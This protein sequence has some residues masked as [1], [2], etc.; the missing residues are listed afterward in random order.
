ME[1]GSWLDPV[2][3]AVEVGREAQVSHMELCL[4][5]HTPLSPPDCGVSSLSLSLSLTFIFE[6][7]LMSRGGAERRGDRGS[8]AGSALSAQIP[9]RGSSPRTVR[10]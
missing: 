2:G 6:R 5:S 1:V 4:S 8:E 9:M 7:E 3:L 10:S